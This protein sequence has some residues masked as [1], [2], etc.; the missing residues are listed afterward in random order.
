[1]RAALN[2]TDNG[3]QIV[4]FWQAVEMFSPESL[5]EPDASSQ[6]AD[7]GP[8]ELMPWEAGS[9]LSA[10]QIK[11]GK[12]W[13]HQVFG[14]IYELRRVRD[15]IVAM[16]DDNDLGSGR[17]TVPGESALFACTIDEDG[18]LIEE[19]ALLSACACAI[20]WASAH[21]GSPAQWR[22]VFHQASRRFGDEL[23]QLAG[24][25]VPAGITPPARLKAHALTCEDLHHFTGE[26]A[27]RL[28]TAQ[29]L[30]PSGIRVKSYL[31]SAT[32]ADYQTERSFLNSYYSDDLA[33]VGEALETDNTGPAL[34]AYL[35]SSPQLESA[36]RI[37]VRREPSA[38]WAGCEP[39][40]IPLGR[41]VTDTD[42]ALAFSQQFAVNQIM[43]LTSS[44][45]LFAVNGPPGTGK[46]TML[47]DLVAA[48]V[49]ERAIGLATLD[50]PGDAFTGPKYSWPT[51]K[52]RHEIVSPS[53]ALTGFEMTVASSNNGAVENVTKEIPGL[54]AIGFQWRDAARDAS[55]FTETAGLVWGDDAWAM[56]AAM[57]GNRQNRHAFVQNFWW[58]TPRERQDRKSPPSFSHAAR[59]G[60]DDGAMIK[61]L[62]TLDG[63]PVDWAAVTGA[64]RR[65][66]GRVT[67]LAAERQEVAVA[68][69]RSRVCERRL[70]PARDAFRVAQARHAATAARQPAI[71]DRLR[72]AD[73]CQRDARTELHAHRRDKPGLLSS[74]PRL[75]AARREWRAAHRKL[76]ERYRN[77][78]RRRDA[79]EN[80]ASDIRSRVA[81]AWRAELKAQTELDELTREI[82]HVRRLISEARRRWGEHVPAGPEYAKT[83]NAELIERREKS[84]VWADE[85]FTAA[86]TEL[87][88]AA[89]MLHKALI[90]AQAATIRG[91]LGALADIL[92]GKGRPGRDATM[93]AWQTF[94]LVVPVVSSTFASTDRLFAGLGREAMGWLFIDEAGQASPQQAV[95]AMWRAKRVVVTGDPLQLQ[96]VVTLPWS[97]QQ[98]LLRK[99]GVAEE[100]APS[101]GSVQRVADRLARH[102]TWLPA[103]TPGGSDRV[104]VGTP[105][106]VHRRCERPIFDISNQIAYDGLMVFGTKDRGAFHGR[107][108][109]WDVRSSDARG[110]WIPAEGQA[111]RET[112]ERLRRAG[113]P[114]AEIRVMSP[115]KQ[116]TGEA[117][118]I[119]REVFGESEVSSDERRDWVGT[120][121][122][123]QGKEADVVIL[124]LG[125]NPARPGAR[126]FAIESPHLLNVA[127][128]RARRRLYVIGNRQIWGKER[129]F[130]VLAAHLAP[131]PPPA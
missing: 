120:V 98:A 126:T 71:D 121:H 115:F 108:V 94:F 112:L 30:A 96:P 33:R 45:G 117:I 27:D 50:T 42:H 104:W 91:N 93:A 57:L 4:R 88:L 86:R 47:R 56:I 24:S 75:P 77:A 79:A 106:R 110:H 125:G 68:I 62:K 61:V 43:R 10:R 21:G 67:A 95:G 41:W 28:G 90:T 51:G 39:A 52:L 46:T 123:M 92:D 26:L 64:F 35:T 78:T 89:L 14:G 63:R 97:A 130:S 99:F 74:W 31:V 128:S 7:I 22:A 44:H 25:P 105:L 84:A 6:V 102:G 9:Q 5:P 124:V 72:D 129:Y 16:F 58:G 100:W 114:A 87:F 80:E 23:G 55:Y 73:T 15:Q 83:D 101:R 2:M 20:G 37:D 107:D 85:E 54:A 111:L 29:I 70:E 11:P 109:W 131:W 36:T 113:V 118:S 3:T 1:M 122:K 32:R 103:A 66:L 69:S 19:S 127:V 34:K 13:R 76:G 17:E 18:L 40:R 116:V 65:V 59:R 82:E 48:I 8:G 81:G 38:V 53:P 49:V 12:V 119:H 60:R